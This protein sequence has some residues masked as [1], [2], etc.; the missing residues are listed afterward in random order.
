MVSLLWGDQEADLRTSKP[1]DRFHF[2]PGARAPG[3]YLSANLSADASSP[4]SIDLTLLVFEPKIASPKNVAARTAIDAE[5]YA[6][7]G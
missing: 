7:A 4:S 6:A 1:I 5:K 3:F 2:R